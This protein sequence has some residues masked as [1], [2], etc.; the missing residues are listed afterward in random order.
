MD[1]TYA[2]F[3]KYLGYY[4]LCEEGKTFLKEASKKIC[5]DE[6]LVSRALEL[7]TKLAD[8]SLELKPDEE[9][10]DDSTQFGA[11]LFTLAIED[12][13]KLYR[14][15]NI[16]R[17]VLL[18]TIGDLGVWIQRHYD[19]FGEWGFS[20][21]GWVMG[22]LRAKI[23]KL[24][25]LQFEPKKL[26]KLPPAELNL[27]L[28]QGDPIL[29]VHI[30]RGGRLDEN[31]CLKSFESAERFFPDVL[32]YDF[33]AFGCFTWLFDPNFESLLP[34]DSNILKFQ[35]MFELFPGEEGYWGLD[36]VFVNIT[37]ENI[38]DAPKDTAFRKNLAEHLLAGGKMQPGCGYRL[39]KNRK[40]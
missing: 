38:K 22:H 21:H 4:D 34:P 23:F 36:Y 3:E 8:L 17:D 20:Q 9:F 30:P 37:K 11:F 33:A 1:A 15:K 14:Q 40:Q 26:D 2:K 32:G 35:K 6:S 5:E 13:E 28:K 29:N 10:K 24:G 18:E 19:W 39:A 16:P 7:K 27:N 12:M 31:A 25:R